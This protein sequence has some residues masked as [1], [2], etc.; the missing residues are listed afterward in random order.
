MTPL[1]L[2]W[3][4]ATPHADPGPPPPVP[5]PP[6]PPAP[7]GPPPSGG[8][9]TAQRREESRLARP[10]KVTAAAAAALAALAVASAV[11]GWLP[12]A[13][14]LPVAV[15]ALAAAGQRG[16]AVARGER[17]LRGRVAAE[18]VRAARLRADQ[19]SRVRGTQAE[20]GRRASQWR[21]QWSAFTTQKRWYAVPVPGGID[22]VDVA[23]GTLAG[24]SA[25]LT[26]AAAY[27]LTAGGEATV[28]DLSGG[29]AAAA[30]A[31][32]AAGGPGAGGPGA[33]GPGEGPPA[34]WVLPQDLPRLD[35]AAPLSPAELADVLALSVSVAEDNSS[36]RDLALDTRSWTGSSACSTTGTGPGPAAC[37]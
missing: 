12:A 31:G 22:R 8:W 25:L 21:A 28:I 23:G 20:H 13:V 32:P 19:E 30:Q 34:V 5:D 15:L 11:A 16:Y 1:Y 4:Y 24:W 9:L 36:A 3:Q 37:R 17:Q 6:G 18:E 35:I 10:L 7:P 2:G 29:S 33:G 27:Q 26:M 14:A